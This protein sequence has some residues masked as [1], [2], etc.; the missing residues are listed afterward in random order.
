MYNPNQPSIQSTEVTP[1]ESDRLKVK[2]R[3]L[4][5]AALEEI[6]R[7]RRHVEDLRDTEATISAPIRVRV[8]PLQSKEQSPDQTSIHESPKEPE[9]VK[10]SEGNNEVDV[11]I[12]STDEL[13]A[14]GQENL[15]A[16]NEI[17]AKMQELATELGINLDE[18]VDLQA[19]GG[20]DLE[21]ESGV[22]DDPS[23]ELDYEHASLEEL[24]DALN[25]SL[26]K[27]DAMAKK[28]DEMEKELDV[29]EDVEPTLVAINAD[30]SYDKKAL[31]HDLAEREL[32]AEL[33]NQKGFKRFIRSI[34]KGNIARKYY[35]AKY[36]RE[37]EEGKRTTNIDGEEVNLDDIIENRKDAAIERFILGITEEYG[38][39]FIHRKAGEDYEE[40]EKT[41]ELIRPI[42]ED[43]A[44]ELLEEGTDLESLKNDKEAR[45]IF[46]NR[47][48]TLIA[49]RRDGG[50]AIN[51]ILANNYFEVAIQAAEMARH[52]DGIERVMN[53]FKVYNAKVRDGIRTEAHRNNIDRI[54]DKL[55]SKFGRFIP[56]EVLA[57]AV[58]G[59]S[60][61]TRIGVGSVARAIIPVGGIAV[62][63]ALSGIREKNRVTD[64]RVRMMRDAAVGLEYVP[65]DEEPQ[66][67]KAR[68]RSKYEAEIHGT[69][70]ELRSAKSLTRDIM[71][72][73]ESGDSDNILRAIAE[74]RVR[75]DYSDAESRDLIG[76]SSADR[77]G[78]E[79]LKLDI[80]LI[81]AEHNLSDEDKVKLDAI[82][83]VVEASLFGGQDEETGEYVAGEISDKDENFNRIRAAMA[84][85]RA[86]K[87]AA[88]GAVAFFASQ[89]I[90]ATLRPDKIS[91][92][93]KAGIFRNNNSE[94]ASESI[95]ARLVRSNRSQEVTNV[96]ATDYESIESLRRNGYE[97]DES[98]T[99]AGYTSTEVRE[100]FVEISPEESTN[101]IKINI[102][103]YADNGTRVADGNELRAYLENGQMVSGMYGNSTLPNGE[104]LNYDELLA[105]GRIKACVNVNGANFEIVGKLNEAGQMTWMDGGIATTTTGETMQLV[106]ENGEKFY[107]S[108]MIFADNGVDSDGVQH[109][110]SLATDP[111]GG[112]F[113]GTISQVVRDNLAIDH[114][115]ILTFVKEPSSEIFT[116]GIVAPD[117][118]GRT[119]LGEAS[120]R[121]ESGSTPAEQE[122]G[123]PT[124]E[125]GSNSPE[126]NPT[127]PENDDLGRNEFRA[128]LAQQFGTLF[129]NYESIENMIMGD[130][131]EFTDNLRSI[132]WGSL[133][134]EAQEAIVEF[135]KSS[136]SPYDRAFREWLR[137]NNYDIPAE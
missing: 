133:D 103:G 56:A 137:N 102:D 81:E 115:A 119:G 20:P 61:F 96:S 18:I 87:T 124:D 8:K 1:S 26:D 45:R 125:G 17:L 4:T 42:I 75:I 35:E 110:I 70:Y 59:I 108:F 99:V 122:G 21:T 64:D 92:L 91:A 24:M 46:N 129:D 29:D 52:T 33:S 54:V 136:N 62:S 132:T 14:A 100:R 12:A 72:A 82:K 111:A 114:P 41:T 83:R 107:N 65:I 127:N 89:E 23:S 47:L 34:W 19:E 31:A 5:G 112:T 27:Q 101:Q 6:R 22:E 30:F 126:A 130:G 80:A 57:A 48:K 53:G 104:V 106:G 79:R 116:G 40:D 16:Q 44:K 131:E 15:D 36:A 28:I 2:V 74:A 78:D 58:G 134:K 90:I 118:R 97:I 32:N 63:A 43:Y 11:S 71:E 9:V 13:L 7:A 66:S 67:R 50:E 51:E 86:G 117:L 55:D 49:E 60:A 123:N 94:D 76:Y 68:R 84:M 128:L 38:D 121:P 93:E 39:Q 95:I 37:F 77:I 25:D 113:N 73:E 85:K 69:L 105:A 109:A 88:I 98:R 3:K 10:E 135:E 120:L